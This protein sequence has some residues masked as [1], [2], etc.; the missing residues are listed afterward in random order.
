MISRHKKLP[1][2]DP[3]YACF[4][5][6]ARRSRIQ[7][8]GVYASQPI[9]VRRKVI[10]YTGEKINRQ[11]TIRR[12]NGRHYHYIFRLSRRWFLDGRI[13]GSGAQYINHC[14]DPNLFSWRTKGHIILM[15]RRRIRTGEELTLDYH[16][17][18]G[19]RRVLCR[20]GSPRCRGTI[21]LKHP[22]YPR[23]K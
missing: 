22:R 6:Q 7:G 23:W 2:I 9:P 12:L 21:N 16:Y 13:G 10:E 15:S 3:R 8:L 4:R 14:C 18:P 17:A 20:C 19:A 1:R 5:L 11:E